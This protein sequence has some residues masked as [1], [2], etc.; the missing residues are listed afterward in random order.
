MKLE[1]N[2]YI[3]RKYNCKAN[4]L[5]NWIVK[6]TL[7]RQWFKDE[8]PILNIFFEV[9]SNGEFSIELE[10]ENSLVKI[11][12]KNYDEKSATF[13]LVEKFKIPDENIKEKSKKWHQMLLKLEELI[14]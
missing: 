1:N 3:G 8:N 12:I 10:K 9:N 6:P 7:F 13:S 4:E 14:F 11:L 2:I 5:C